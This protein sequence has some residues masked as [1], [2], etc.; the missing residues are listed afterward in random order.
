MV[1][2]SS[3]VNGVLLAG[4]CSWQCACL[5]AGDDLWLKV[6]VWCKVWGVSMARMCLYLVTCCCSK[7]HL[8]NHVC[9]SFMPSSK[10]LLCSD[11]VL[12]SLD[13]LT[14]CLRW[15]CI[16]KGLGLW[17]YWCL[18]VKSMHFAPTCLT[19][20]R[21]NLVICVI[22]T[23]TACWEVSHLTRSCWL[24]VCSRYCC[25]VGGDVQSMS[26]RSLAS[27]GHLLVLAAVSQLVH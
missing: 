20:T 9:S 4:I 8:R 25:L 11:S 22:L 26:S 14:S 16:W 1:G 12:V 2:C 13:M 19:C 7:R 21:W 27:V 23:C 17:L 18:A 5:L 15:P 6:W 10:C 24:C 3:M